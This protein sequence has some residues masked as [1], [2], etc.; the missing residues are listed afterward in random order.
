M[1]FSL[2]LLMLFSFAMW[3][4][5]ALGATTSS[6]S[7]SKSKSN[8]TSSSSSKSK[9][10]AKTDTAAK[11]K[12]ETAAEKLKS[13]TATKEEAAPAPIRP[14]AVST[15]SVEQLSGF[16][17]YPKQIQSLVQSCLALTHLELRYLYGSH[18]PSNGGMDCSGTIYHVLH[19]QGLKDV[20]RQSDE[21][22]LW[23][24]KKTQLHLTATAANFDSP[25]FD[26]LKPGDLLFWTNTTATTRK[27]P[28]THVMIYL[29]K[30]KDSGKRVVFGASDGRSYAGHRRSGVS[31]FDFNLPRPESASRL[32]GYGRAPGLLPAEVPLASATPKP[33]TPES[34]AKDKQPASEPVA[35]TAP[36]KSEA[37]KDPVI[38]EALPKTV[39]APPQEEAPKEPV[40]AASP[41]QKTESTP[42]PKEEV[43]K[44]VAMDADASQKSSDVEAAASASTTAEVKTTETKVEPKKA[45]ATTSKPKSSSSK[46]KAS[47]TPKKKVSTTVSSRRRTPAPP[48]KNSVERA[49]DNAVT[50]VRRLF[51]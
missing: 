16:D 20:P 6:K 47:T 36:K 24:D 45:P 43:R 2:R 33:E 35:T 46:A 26:N 12:V 38:T 8:T 18:E 23:V 49:M 32:H 29:G 50:S 51:R 25:E 44:A 48:P 5:H 42:E 4:G 3:S 40:V 17:K 19:F 37:S 39:S 28:V 30:L 34:T 1:Q 41:P 31:V 21:M 9:P 10:S 7:K 27:L 22:A 11:S 14:A 13:E 15:I